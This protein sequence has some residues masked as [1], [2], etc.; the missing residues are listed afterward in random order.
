M[1]V[2]RKVD[3]G[4]EWD[5]VTK[6]KE[7]LSKRSPLGEMWGDYYVVRPGA[8][9]DNEWTAIIAHSLGTGNEA[10]KVNLDLARFRV[11]DNLKPPPKT[12]EA[13]ASAEV[14]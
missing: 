14:K 6:K 1:G 10:A 11:R 5:F 9:S 12:T 8:N 3:L 2:L 13:P 7:E 4:Y